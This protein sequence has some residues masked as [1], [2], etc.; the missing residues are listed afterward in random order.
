VRRLG[1]TPGGSVTP[2]VEPWLGVT[3]PKASRKAVDVGGLLVALDA[4]T[5]S[6]NEALDRVDAAVVQV[7][8]ARRVLE[9]RH[10]EARALVQVAQLREP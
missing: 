4:D 6:S 1:A 5:G 9:L 2:E 10:V 8:E 3:P 7:A